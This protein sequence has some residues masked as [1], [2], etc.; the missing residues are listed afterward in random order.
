MQK[1]K[2]QKLTENLRKDQLC[3]QASGECAMEYVAYRLSAHCRLEQ[4]KQEHIVWRSTKGWQGAQSCPFQLRE[5]TVTDIIL[6]G[7]EWFIKI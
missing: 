6:T 4:Q 1:R 2:F 3:C 7:A 5:I